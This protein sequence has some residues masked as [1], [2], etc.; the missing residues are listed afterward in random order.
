MG[1]MLGTEDVPTIHGV[2]TVVDP[3][4]S[5]KVFPMT[6]SRLEMKDSVMATLIMATAILGMTD[7]GNC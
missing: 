7:E 3:T 2:M 1:M 4:I 5:S 6:I